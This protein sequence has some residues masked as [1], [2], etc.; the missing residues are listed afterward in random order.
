MLEFENVNP[1]R[2]KPELNFRPQIGPIIGIIK[3]KFYSNKFHLNKIY[4]AFTHAGLT[5][6]YRM[7]SMYKII[8]VLSR[9]RNI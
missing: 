3:G 4:V 1:N 2:P 6:R 5:T 8:F 7:E 9:P